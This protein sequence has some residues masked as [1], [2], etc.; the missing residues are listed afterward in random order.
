MKGEGVSLF[1]RRQVPWYA[2]IFMVLAV[3]Y[4]FI[5]SEKL[6]PVITRVMDL[7]WWYDRYLE[8]RKRFGGSF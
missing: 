3:I 7:D 6:A 4:G 2:H 8:L 1:R 5:Q